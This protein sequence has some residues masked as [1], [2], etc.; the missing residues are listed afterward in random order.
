MYS[1]DRIVVGKDGLEYPRKGKIIKAIPNKQTGYYQVSL[2][3]NNKGTWHYIHRLLAQHFIPNPLNKPEINHKD[4]DRQN[5]NLNN[6][7]WVTSKENSQHAIQ[8]GLTTY[9]NRLTRDEFITC[10]QDVIA[11]ES[12]KSLSKRVPYKIPFL[13]TK[14]RQIAKEIGLENELNESLWQQKLERAKINGINN[15][16]YNR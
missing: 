16:K 5:N 9:T 6:L 11:G 12:Y 2:W 8:T 3:K 4:G 13:S 15:R 1:V 14:L 10:L 7:E